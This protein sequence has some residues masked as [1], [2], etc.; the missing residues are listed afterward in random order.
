MD[1]TVKF[2]GGTMRRGLASQSSVKA[3]RVCLPVSSVAPQSQYQPK[4]SHSNRG[5]SLRHRCDATVSKVPQPLQ[6]PCKFLWNS[7]WRMIENLEGTKLWNKT[8]TRESIP[9][10]LKLECAHEP[11]KDLIKRQ[12][13]I[14]WPWGCVCVCAGS[15]FLRTSRVALMLGPFCEQQG[16]YQPSLTRWR[17]SQGS[18]CLQGTWLLNKSDDFS[19]SADSDTTKCLS[20]DLHHAAPKKQKSQNKAGNGNS[21]IQ[22]QYVCTTSVKLGKLQSCCNAALHL[23]PKALVNPSLLWCCNWEPGS[24][25]VWMKAVGAL[26]AQ[27]LYSSPLTRISG[28]TG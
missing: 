20:S 5:H 6:K 13:W 22:L 25:L 27:Q 9:A 23:N 19:P 18:C 2:A 24:W 28:G 10:R 8:R 11:P 7:L 14:H 17:S 12:L 21:R 26:R 16:C 4:Q 3:R 1:N 15:V